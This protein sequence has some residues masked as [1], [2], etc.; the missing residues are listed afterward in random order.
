MGSVNT[1]RR[2]YDIVQN[3][4]NKQTIYFPNDV[5][6]ST[7]NILIIIEQEE[8]RKSSLMTKNLLKPIAQTEFSEIFVFTFYLLFYFV[9]YFGQLIGTLAN[10]L[11]VR[12][13]VGKD[14]LN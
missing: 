3:K 6:Y 2:V 4:E 12:K 9:N 11:S 13:Q 8:R 10:G 14:F 7:T 1:A 5:T